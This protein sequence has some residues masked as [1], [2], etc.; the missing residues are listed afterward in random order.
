MTKVNWHV[1]FVHT[2]QEEK[3]IQILR[4][5]WDTEMYTPFVFTAEK[6][7]KKAGRFENERQICFPGYVFAESRGSVAEFTKAAKESI[8]EVK[9]ICRVVDYGSKGDIVMHREEVTALKQLCDT[10]KCIKM[11]T[12]VIE[13]GRVQVQSGALSG[14]EGCIRKIDRHRREALIEIGFMGGPKQMKVG[15]EIVSKSSG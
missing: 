9:E 10:N 15:L 14:K 7:F 11:S 4:K 6:A 5:R 13:G 3:V 1:L 2:G 8:W 12:G